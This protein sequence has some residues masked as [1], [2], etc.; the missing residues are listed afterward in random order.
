MRYLGLLALA[1][2]GT[3][4]TELSAQVWSGLTDDTPLVGVTVQGWIA[5]TMVAEAVTDE[6]GIFRWTVPQG[7]RMRIRVQGEGLRPADFFGETGLQESFALAAGSLYGVSEE[8]YA[9]Q[10]AAFEGCPGFDSPS[11]G[12]IIGELRIYDDSENGGLPALLGFSRLYLTEDTYREACYLDLEGNYD[13]DLE[14]A[15]GGGAFAFFGIPE[16]RY[17]LEVGHDA[18]GVT[19]G[20]AFEVDVFDGAVFPAIPT[21]LDLF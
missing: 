19:P 9:E 4:E 8:W 21:W 18:G 15:V 6:L 17:P 14:S 1:A 16:G 3:Q 12:S 5:D 20:Y 13:P 11:G 10:T 2:C 7:A